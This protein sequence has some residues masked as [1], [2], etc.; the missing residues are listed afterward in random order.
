MYVS[1]D[2]I[3]LS[4]LRCHNALLYFK[5]IYFD[6]TLVCYVKEKMRKNLFKNFNEN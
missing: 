1:I 4:I 6:N 5:D 2:L 3:H